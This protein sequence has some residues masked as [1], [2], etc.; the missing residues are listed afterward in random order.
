MK[1]LYLLAFLL[2]GRHAVAERCFLATLDDCIRPNRVFKG[3]ERSWSK[4]CLISNAIH[5]VFSG[6]AESGG[7]P[8]SWSGV[9]VESGE[10]SG[11]NALTG[12]TPPLQRF[13]LVMSVLE[14]YS[15]RECAL[16]LRCALRDVAEA[17]VH[18]L[19][20]LSSFNSIADQDSTTKR[21]LRVA[22]N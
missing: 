8:D 5:L 13:V 4:R 2:T 18:G 14:K 12:L 15:E 3:W 11:L 20:Q 6:P 21:N 19:Q 17:R 22:A 9:D 10:C 1:P 16:L 7:K